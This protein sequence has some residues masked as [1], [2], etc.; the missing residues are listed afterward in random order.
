MKYEL[1]N[2]KNVA[3]LLQFVEPT[4]ELETCVFIDFEENGTLRSGIC[5]DEKPFI[6]KMPAG[7]LQGS[8]YLVAQ[9]QLFQCN[10]GRQN[11][12]TA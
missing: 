4:T 9:E 12:E 8:L 10:H 1:R 2:S 7:L 5:S 3:V 11:V 6:C